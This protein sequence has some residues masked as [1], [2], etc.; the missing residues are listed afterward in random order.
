MFADS[1][2]WTEEEIRQLLATAPLS[3]ENASEVLQT[4]VGLSPGDYAVV[5]VTEARG[6]TLKGQA[7]W[8]SSLVGFDE[9]MR[10]QH[11]GNLDVANLSESILKKHC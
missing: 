8:R 2:F 4:P 9:L 7:L 11:V 3:V 10:S 1:Q 6:H 5:E